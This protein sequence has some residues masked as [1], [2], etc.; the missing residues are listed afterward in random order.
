[1][2]GGNIT[3]NNMVFNYPTRPEAK[4]LRGL[5]INVEKGQTLA[6]VGSSGCGRST[7]VQL[8]ERFY[9]PL[10]GEMVN[11]FLS[12][13]AVR[14]LLTHTCPRLVASPIGNAAQM[15]HSAGLGTNPGLHLCLFPVSRNTVHTGDR[16]NQLS[17]GQKQRVATAPALVRQPRFLLLDGGTSALDTENEMG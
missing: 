15:S 8:L 14:R 5:N 17:G 12:S 16:E 1:I 13:A 11:V 9:D 7:V 4:V 6:L 3:F 10:S 2:F